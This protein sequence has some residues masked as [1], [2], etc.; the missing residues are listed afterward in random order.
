MSYRE[1]WFYVEQL[2]R[3]AQVGNQAEVERLLND[4][5][6]V[7][8]FD[9]LCRTPLHYAVESGH[10]ATAELLVSRGADVNAHDEEKI[11]ETPLSFAVQGNCLEMVELLMTHGAN[12][13]ITG[14]MGTTAWSRAHGRG[15]DIGKQ[16]CA[17]IARYTA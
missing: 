17:I 11:G 14:W 1:D 12:S 4:G 2:H 5:F 6:D 15:D 16:I 13:K 9:D 7:N 3:A 10:Y 8:L